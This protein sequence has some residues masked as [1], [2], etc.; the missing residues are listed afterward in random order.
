[1]RFG[2]EGAFRPEAV[3]TSV[4][5]LIDTPVLKMGKGK[6]GQP[7]TQWDARFILNSVNPLS[8]TYG[9]SGEAI[10]GADG[11]DFRFELWTFDQQK[12]TFGEFLGFYTMPIQMTITK[13]E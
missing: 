5:M 11:D 2:A 13:R 1:M 4:N 3:T 12:G 10:V 6:K 8:L 9:L 7:Y